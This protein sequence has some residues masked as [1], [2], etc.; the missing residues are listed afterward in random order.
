M[1]KLLA[2]ECHLNLVLIART[3]SYLQQAK[4]ELTAINPDI[5]VI[6]ICADA[7]APDFDSLYTLL[8]DLDI[9]LLINNIGI[10][11]HVPANT[12]ELTFAEIDGII[13]VNCAFT[14]KFTAAVIPILKK[15]LHSSI[16]N[17]SSLTSRMAM[18]MLSLYA[19][20]KAFE[21]HW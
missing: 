18:P 7:A 4:I 19:A 2:R 16:V 9:S 17:I 20:T 14:V 11:N 5:R 21:D 13:G 6:L 15:Q 10:H 8:K 1:G 12:D 3:P